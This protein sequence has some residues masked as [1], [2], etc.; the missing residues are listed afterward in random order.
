MYSVMTQVGVE[1][2]TTKADSFYYEELWDEPV[3]VVTEREE[4]EE[5]KEVAV[6]MEKEEDN[7]GSA[8][9]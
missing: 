4:L 5:E 3:A 8:K 6:V 1:I 2:N 9:V 7:L